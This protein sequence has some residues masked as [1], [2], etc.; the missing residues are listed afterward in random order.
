M[1]KKTSELYCELCDYKTSRTTNMNYH[2]ES[3]KHKTNEKIANSKQQTPTPECCQT[4]QETQNTNNEYLKKCIDV[5][6]EKYNNKLPW[7]NQFS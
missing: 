5:Y 6:I 2:Y 1:S 4:P 3:K 7:L